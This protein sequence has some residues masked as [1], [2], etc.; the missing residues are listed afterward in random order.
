MLSKILD[1]NSKFNEFIEIVIVKNHPIRFIPMSGKKTSQPYSQ[2]E[3]DELLAIFDQRK[4][5]SAELNK[6]IQQ[7]ANVIEQLKRLMK[8]QNKNYNEL[9]Q[10]L[11][12]LRQKQAEKLRKIN[13]KYRDEANQ[14]AE[15]INEVHKL[16]QEKKEVYRMYSERMNYVRFQWH[17]LESQYQAHLAQ[18]ELQIQT[19][20]LKEQEILARNQNLKAQILTLSSNPNYASKKEFIKKYS[21]KI[22]SVQELAIKVREK[23]EILMETKNKCTDLHKRLELL[24]K[25]KAQS[26]QK[27]KIQMDQNFLDT[28]KLSHQSNNSN[29]LKISSSNPYKDN[30]EKLYIKPQND[31]KSPGD[32]DINFNSL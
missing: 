6:E 2:L 20:Q 7:T 16:M 3:K 23:E 13:E 27:K 24:R 10:N 11:T 17:Q 12:N 9:N 32:N 21:S 19:A 8:S 25:R 14:L 29:S 30:L 1:E 5:T 15:V 18:G 26:L 4:K 22:L 28:T 31:I